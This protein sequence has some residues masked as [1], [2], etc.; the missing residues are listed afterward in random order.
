MGFIM[1]AAAILAL[2]CF[3]VARHF[4]ALAPGSESGFGAPDPAAT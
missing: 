1:L 4:V 2:A 3:T